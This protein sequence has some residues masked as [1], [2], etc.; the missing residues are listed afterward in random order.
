ML[1]MGSYNSSIFEKNNP[2]Y[3]SMYTGIK[4]KKYIHFA[5]LKMKLGSK[6]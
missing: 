1:Q 4:L 5:Y 3:E 6:Q 2:N